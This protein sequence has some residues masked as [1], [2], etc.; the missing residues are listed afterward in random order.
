LLQVSSDCTSD[1]KG[2]DLDGRSDGSSEIKKQLRRNRHD[3]LMSASGVDLPI[4]IAK[5][6]QPVHRQ[7]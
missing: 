2:S 4:E 7:A 5:V 1:V 6:R 3:C